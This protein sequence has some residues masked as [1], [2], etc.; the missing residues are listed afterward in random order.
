MKSRPGFLLLALGM[1]ALTGCGSGEVEKQDA[2]APAEPDLELIRGLYA[3]GH[4][5]RAL[6]PCGEVEDLWVIDSSGT[7]KA[8]HGALAM[9]TP[10][11]TSSVDLSDVER[12]ASGGDASVIR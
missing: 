4:E 12:L 5:V 1:I 10:G 2:Q 6:Q 8:A 9:T 7:L 11:D 3:F